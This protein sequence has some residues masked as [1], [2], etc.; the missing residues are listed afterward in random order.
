MGPTIRLKIYTTNGNKERVSQIYFN[1][2]IENHR[3][4]IIEHTVDWTPKE[5]QKLLARISLSM[6]C[7]G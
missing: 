5:I 2:A 7:V 6:N 3:D 1:D 4:Y